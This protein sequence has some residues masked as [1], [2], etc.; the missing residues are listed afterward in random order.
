MALWYDA[1]GGLRAKCKYGCDER[2][3]LAAV[4]VPKGKHSK[5][6]AC[7]VPVE[8]VDWFAYPYLAKGMIA[9]I[10]SD[11]GVGKSYI[12]SALAVAA[13]VGAR[14]PWAPDPIPLCRSLIYATEDVAKYTTVP[15]LM[16]M[17]ANLDMIDIVEEVLPLTAQGLIDLER[18][19]VDSNAGLVIID[20]VTACLEASTVGRNQ[21][22][23]YHA[24]MG[25]LKAIAE[26]T[27]AC[28]IGIRHLTKA[29]GMGSAIHAGQGPMAV[30]AKFRTILQIRPDPDHPGQ[31][32]V[33]Q[34]KSNIGPYGDPFV[35]Q[36]KGAGKD[37][38]DLLWIGGSDKV[39]TDVVNVIPEKRERTSTLI[40]AK[41]FLC[42]MLKDGA[43]LQAAIEREGKSQG[44]SHI[45]I[46]RAKLALGVKSL[47]PLH[48]D[49][50]GW[51]WVLGDVPPQGSYTPYKDD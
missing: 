49:I 47:S 3:L 17:G 24:C 19:I 31:N 28:I 13:S 50:S 20:P 48:K 41:E 15:R 12:T 6:R 51:Q 2:K 39:I 14:L 45:T 42:D 26:R 23:D 30:G 11:P 16:Q 34:I 33:F 1:N 25:G 5:M 10:E 32:I 4:P 8:A 29:N 22:I 43:V 44:F 36:I 18:E 9:G 46:K 27:N 40:A 35:Y 21:S 38:A 7:H 37:R